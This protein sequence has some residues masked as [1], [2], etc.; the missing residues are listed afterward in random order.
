MRMRWLVVSF[1]LVLA[2]PAAA[3]SPQR[4]GGVKPA[5]LDT[6]CAPCA[7]FYRFANGAWLSTFQIPPSQSSYGSF[8]ELYDRNQ[9]NVH[10]LLEDAARR[11]TQSTAGSDDWKIGVFYSTC[12]DSGRADAEG[13]KPLAP[14]LLKI[15]AV[16][17]SDQ[18]ARAVGGL[19]G[20]TVTAMFR[21]Y[22]RQDP[23]N[24]DSVMAFAAQGGLGLPDRDYY[25]RTDSTSAALREF[26]VQHIERTL[27]LTGVAGGDAA[28]A[29]KRIL[30]IETALARASMTNVQVRDPHLT[31]HPMSVKALRALAPRFAWDGYFST[32][33][34]PAFGRVNVGQPD[35]FH[36]LDSLLKVVSIEDWRA[37]L[38]WHLTSHAAPWLSSAFVREDFAFASRLSGEKEMKPRWKRC[39]ELTDQSIGEALG[40][41]FVERHFTPAT[42]ERALEMVK[43]LEAALEDRLGTLE[44]MNDTTRTQAL[45]KLHAFG[46]KIG[47]PDRWRDYSALTVTPHALLQNVLDA[48]RFETRRRLSKI[49]GPVDRGEWTMTPPTVNAYYSATLNEIVFPAGILQPPFFDPYADDASNYGSMG[50]VIGHEMTHGFDDRGRQYDARGNLRDWWTAGDTQRFKTRAA[51]VI[52][53]FNGYTAV[54]TVHLNGKLTTGENIADLGGLAVAYLAFQKSFAGKPHPAPI[55]GFTAEQRFFLSYAQIWHELVRPEQARLWASTDPHS[56]GRWRVIGPLSNLP[57]FAAAFG[58]KSGDRMVRP[59][60]VRVRIW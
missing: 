22:A 5:Y 35:F 6:T 58:C 55:G 46:R 54:D 25:L 1:T 15:E 13:M 29:A 7:D 10:A 16:K 40:R 56:P 27:A 48:N 30:E 21:L 38:R 20:Q 42:R 59:D 57:E 9:E 12:M 36:A 11:V 52:D 2:A 34:A 4:L 8:E 53:Q 33:P 18:L 24:S 28:R 49:G 37:Y 43:N 17:T 14:L 44:W 39:M 50:A 23:A 31:N 60:S 45:G 32:V 51:K 41:A 3:Q 47:Y 26:Y 19:H